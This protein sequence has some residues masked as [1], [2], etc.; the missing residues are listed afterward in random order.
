M[1]KKQARKFNVLGT[2]AGPNR[3]NKPSKPQQEPDSSSEDSFVLDSPVES[4]YL[5]D[6]GCDSDNET[7]MDK[8]VLRAQV[9]QVCF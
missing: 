2:Q 4:Y 6:S 8:P 5:P 3:Q 1:G 7:P 9:K